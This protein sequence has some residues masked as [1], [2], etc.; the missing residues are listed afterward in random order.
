MTEKRLQVNVNLLESHEIKYGNHPGRDAK[1][2]FFSSGSRYI[3]RFR[4]YMIEYKEFWHQVVYP[5]Q[6]ERNARPQTFLDSFKVNSNKSVENASS[7]NF[8]VKTSKPE[9]K[10]SIG[11]PKNWNEKIYPTEKGTTYAYWDD[12][13]NAITIVVREPNSFKRVLTMIKNDQLTEKQVNELEEF[14][15]RNAPLKRQIKVGVEVISNQKALFQSYI[16]R[17]E[18]AGHVYFIKGKEYSFIKNNM[19]YKISFS[20]APVKTEDAAKIKFDETYKLIFY[21]ILI[22]FFVF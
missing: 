12:I 17:Q 14:I 1:L 21:P 16:H 22:T 4:T 19:Q 6:Y 10:F 15:K 3:I 20:P 18:T 9:D 2:E 7:S 11:I 13:G 8:D 5:H